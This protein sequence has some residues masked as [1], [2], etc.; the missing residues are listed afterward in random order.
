MGRTKGSGMGSVYMPPNTLDYL[1]KYNKLHPND[2]YA[3]LNARGGFFHATVIMNRWSKIH[4]I[5]QLKKP[6]PLEVQISADFQGLE[7][8]SYYVAS[9]TI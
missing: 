8:F 1:R 9:G 5:I 4:H 6:K 7:A 2:C 3:F